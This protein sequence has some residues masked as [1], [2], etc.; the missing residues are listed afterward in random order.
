MY[1]ANHCILFVSQHY[2]VIAFKM[3]F[4]ACIAIILTLC[5]DV[6]CCTFA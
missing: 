5:F 6:C 2:D 3:Y 4:H 1:Y